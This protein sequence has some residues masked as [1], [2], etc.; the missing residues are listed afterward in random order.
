MH[1]TFHVVDA[2]RRTTGRRVAAVALAGLLLTGAASC[3]SSDSDG[4]SAAKGSSTTGSTLAGS[5]AEVRDATPVGKATT[6]AT[7]DVQAGIGYVAVRKAEPGSPLVL[8]SKDDDQ[9]ARGTAD[10]YGSLVFRD[11]P[12]GKAFTVRGP[13]G[14]GEVGGSDEVT[15]LRFGDNPKQSFYDDQPVLKEGYQYLTTRDGTKLAVTVRAPIGKTWDQGPFPTL[16]NMSGYADA[17]PDSPTPMGLIASANGFATVSVNERGSGCSGGIAGLFDEIWAADGYDVVETV[18]AQP[19]ATKV[20]LTGISFPGITQ[21]FTAAT[22]PPH[23]A[24]ASPM[25]V[26]AD[27]YRTPGY[28]GGIFNNGF[29]KSWL[30]ERRADGMPAPEGGQGYAVQ[31]VKDGDETCLAN[32]DLRLQTLDPIEITNSTEF[33]VPELIDQRSP[34]NYVSKI[35]VPTLISG[36]WQDEQ[37]GSDFANLF[38]ELPRRKDIKAVLTN[39]VHSAPIEPELLTQ[40]LAF[41][42]IYVAEKVPDLGML[43]AIQPQVAPGSQGGDPEI[44]PFPDNPYANDT[45][46]AEAKARYE[47]LPRY[48]MYF[49]NGGD[50]AKPGLPGGGFEQGFDSWPPKE[51]TATRWFFGPNGTLTD[52]KPTT[53]DDVADRYFPDIDARPMQTIPGQGQSESWQLMPD[54]DWR[55]LVD[56]TAVAYVSPKLDADTAMV[57]TGSVDLWIKANT[58]DTDLQ[59]TLTEVRA[60]GEETYVQNGWLRASH[61]KLDPKRSTPLNPWPTHLEQDAADLPAG[62]FTQARV[63]IFPVAHVFRKGSRIRISVEAPGG[64]RT[65]WSF[66]SAAPPPDA[67]V[68]VGRSATHPS[69]ILLPLITDVDPPATTPACPGLRGQPCRPYQRTLNGG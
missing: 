20:G 21:L 40:W 12:Q 36:A 39:G 18:A 34:I 31:R 22:Q 55:P 5:M 33:R 54:Y 47:A 32:Q 58:K 57:G 4:G 38:G 28:P 13:Q 59:V 44:P 19:W 56:G 8:A 3:T 60:D 29:T 24:A 46:L 1:R 17:D 27:V 68:W 7:F 63:A 14:S 67:Q 50:P 52:A 49:D 30:T 66:E 6:K 41:V 10:R 53:G 43:K 64:D 37:V 62:R 11:L 51:T 26:L 42:D 2:P 61:R 35:E 16:I 69:S 15:T 65:R 23:L 9:V 48:R 45:T 25:S